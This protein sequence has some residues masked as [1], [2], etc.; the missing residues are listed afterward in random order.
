LRVEGADQQKWGMTDAQN[1]P[2]VSRASAA[3]DGRYD[4][5]QIGRWDGPFD[6]L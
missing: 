4:D 1:V 6:G 3:L 2:I 5:G